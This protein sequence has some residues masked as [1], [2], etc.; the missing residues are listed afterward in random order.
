LMSAAVINKTQFIFE[1]E[2]YLFQVEGYQ[3]IFDGYLKTSFYYCKTVRKH[4]KF[5]PY[6]IYKFC[7]IRWDNNINDNILSNC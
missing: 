2:K 7:K 3:M 5:R 1:I 6:I 4:I